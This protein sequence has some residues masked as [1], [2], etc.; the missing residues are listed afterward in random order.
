MPNHS[1]QTKG[2][3]SS[4]YYSFKDETE[5]LRCPLKIV[6]ETDKYIF[7]ECNRSFKK[8]NLGHAVIK[9]SSAITTVEV[10]MRNG[11]EDTLREILSGWFIEKGEEILRRSTGK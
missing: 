9:S 4:I 2:Y 8:E 5:A 6:K 10:A 11:D 7:T 1:V 3:I